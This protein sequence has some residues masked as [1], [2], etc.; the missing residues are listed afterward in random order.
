LFCKGEKSNLEGWRLF[1]CLSRRSD[2]NT[3]VG[4]D[5]LERVPRFA[6]KEDGRARSTRVS[7]HQGRDLLNPPLAGISRQSGEGQ[8]LWFLNY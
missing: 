3:I 1:A 4:A 2:K 5:S 6:A 7:V 8:G